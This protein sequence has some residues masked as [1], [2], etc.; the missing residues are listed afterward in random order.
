MAARYQHMVDTV[1]SSIAQQVDGL[2]WESGTEGPDDD[3]DGLAGA[4]VRIG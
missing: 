3:D 4:L 1:R 2:I